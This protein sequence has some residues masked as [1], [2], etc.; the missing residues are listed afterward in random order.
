MYAGICK[1]FPDHHTLMGMGN[2]EIPTPGLPERTDHR[3]GADP[4]AIGLD[5]CTGS[6]SGSI[7]HAL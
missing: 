3:T 7:K 1:L 6:R 2:E 4:V 5:R